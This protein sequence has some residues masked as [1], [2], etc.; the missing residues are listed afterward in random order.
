MI[1]GHKVRPWAELFSTKNCDF[2]FSFVE[3]KK[4]F[5]R[6][7]KLPVVRAAQVSMQFAPHLTNGNAEGP[8]IADR[9]VE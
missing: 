3:K 8:G 1:T 9:Y 5:G 2:F 6:A 7:G 4:S